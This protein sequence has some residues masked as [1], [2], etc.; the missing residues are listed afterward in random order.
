LYDLGTNVPLA[1][2]WPAAV[3]SGRV[4]EDF[5]SLQD[6]APTL[7]ETAGLKPA[8]EMTGRSLLKILTSNKAGRVDRR[9][10]HILTGKERH[11][12]VRKNGLGCSCRAIRTHEFLY[13]RNFMPDRWPA[14]DPVDGGEPYYSTRAYGDIEGLYDGAS[15]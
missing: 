12:W 11:A 13:I 15:R 8:A 5:G 2:S 10:D 4:V 7:L 3:K 14:G 9:R 6:L 1:V